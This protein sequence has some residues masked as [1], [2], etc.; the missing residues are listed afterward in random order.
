MLDY[1]PYVSAAFTAYPTP[2]LGTNYCVMAYPSLENSQFAIVATADNTT[3]TITPTTNEYLQYGTNSYTVT[4]QQGQTCQTYDSGYF[5]DVTGVTGT[6]IASDKPVGVFAGASLAYV[7]INYRFGNPLVQE[8]L[9]VEQWGM[10]ALSMGFAGRTNG[11][12]YRVLSAYSNT[13]VSITGL[14]VTVNDDYSLTFSNETVV[15]TNQAGQFYDI[16]VDGP[17]EF[18]ASQPVQVAHFANGSEFDVEYG[19]NGDPCEIL[20]PPTGHYLESNSVI[21]LP[22]DYISGDFYTNNLNVIVAQSAIT[23]TLVDGLPVPATNFLAI[24]NS[25]YYG[26][27]L[28][29][30]NSG[31]HTVSSSQPVGV[32]VY[33]W[34][35]YDAYGYFGGVVK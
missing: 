1:D 15:V 28:S 31:T 3:V 4:L 5:N 7:P 19:A 26:A 11:D 9:P 17:V 18:Q 20:L 12:S 8:Q 16:I 35:S 6:W 30:T 10:Q 24:G 32:V 2:L 29:V 13:V 27:Q 22:D 21:T 14:V 33:G 23:N 25:G 34:G